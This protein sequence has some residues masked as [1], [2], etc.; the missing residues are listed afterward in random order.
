MSRQHGLFLKLPALESVELVAASPLD[1]AVV[2]LEH[3]QLSESDALRLVRHA[4]VLGLRALVRIPTVDRGLVNR[5][6]EAGAAGL[7]L[8]TVR[9]VTQVA[10]LRSAMRYAPDGVR[11]IS[12]AHPL[13]GYGGAPLSDYLARCRTRPPLLVAQIETATTDD[14]LDDILSAGVDVAFIGTMDLSVD[15]ELDASRCEARIAEIAD[16]AASVGVTLGAFG[17]ADPR[18]EYDI[19]GSDV[20]LLR[21]AVERAADPIPRSAAEVAR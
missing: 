21:T 9:T 13:A 10:A 15:L 4:H 3:S 8:S 20:A 19:V 14:R 2:D 18:V 17:L 16:A 11:S 7:Q 5:L 6:L 1:F 12:L